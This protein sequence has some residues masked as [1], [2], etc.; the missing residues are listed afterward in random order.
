LVKIL[1][2][3]D[4]IFQYKIDLLDEVLKDSKTRFDVT[5]LAEGG[6]FDRKVMFEKPVEFALVQ[7]EF[8]FEIQI[9]NKSDIG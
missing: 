4:G 7:N 5:N 2:S 1:L 6:P 9:S 3:N 8:D